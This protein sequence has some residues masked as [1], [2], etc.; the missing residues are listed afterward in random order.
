MVSSPPGDDF[1]AFFIPPEIM[2]MFGQFDGRLHGL[3]TA[4][5]EEELIDFPRRNFRQ[6]L[7][8]S[9][10]RRIGKFHRREV[11]E[12]HHLV[13][14][15]LSNLLSAITDVDRPGHSSFKVEVTLS[16]LIKDPNAFP[17]H[18]HCEIV[19]DPISMSPRQD[20]MG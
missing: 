14:G 2:I 13:I 9:E 17:F 10:G 18:D 12:L 1:I 15:G 8:K 16:I 19:S 6:H 4:G 3:R 5:D 7:C 11:A 20:K